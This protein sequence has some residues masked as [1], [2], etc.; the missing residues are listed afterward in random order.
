[1]DGVA[2]V[3]T[4]IAA[5]IAAVGAVMNGRKINRVH[6]ETSLAKNAARRAEESGD[7][8]EQAV[9]ELAN[10]NGNGETHG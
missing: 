10:G 4:S 7:R 5:L 8:V 6:T 1:M 9:T 3:I 2:A